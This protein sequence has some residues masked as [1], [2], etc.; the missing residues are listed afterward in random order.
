[1]IPTDWSFRDHYNALKSELAR[2]AV[3]P[4]QPADVAFF[5]AAGVVVHQLA[6]LEALAEDNGWEKAHLANMCRTP[7][8]AGYSFGAAAA[9]LEANG[10]ERDDSK[11]TSCLVTL[12]QIVFSSS[13]FDECMQISDTGAHDPVYAVAMAA[14]VQ[15]VT[16]FCKEGEHDFLLAN[17]V[18]SEF[19][20]GDHG[21]S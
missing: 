6:L 4:G 13:D 1:M 16:R 5:Q 20:T 7:W 18:R 2:T 12:Q 9:A 15:D 19:I 3:Q 17:H 14:G 8:V 10:L 21:S 11:A